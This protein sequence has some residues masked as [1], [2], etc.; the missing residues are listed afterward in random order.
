[1]K[2][3]FGELLSCGVDVR[4]VTCKLRR[5]CSEQICEMGQDWKG[6]LVVRQ[7]NDCEEGYYCLVINDEY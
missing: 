5:G 6:I 4:W 7:K 1:L 2:S 3:A